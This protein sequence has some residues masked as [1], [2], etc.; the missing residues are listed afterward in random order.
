MSVI[1]NFHHRRIIPLMERELRTF[2]MS[3]TVNL[4]SLV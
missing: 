3:D 1:A 2:E 4:V